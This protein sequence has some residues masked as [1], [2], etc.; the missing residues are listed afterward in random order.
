MKP[1]MCACECD[2]HCE[3]S[4]CLK[5]CTCTKRLIDDLVVMCDEKC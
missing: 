4:E 5:D 2:N 3:I 1:S